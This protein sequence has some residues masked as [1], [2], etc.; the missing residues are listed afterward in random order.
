MVVF[1]DIQRGRR[2]REDQKCE[3][4]NNT[5]SDGPARRNQNEGD[6]EMESCSVTSTAGP[7][8]AAHRE[9]RIAQTEEV[10]HYREQLRLQRRRHLQQRRSSDD[11]NLPD[12]GEQRPIRRRGHLPSLCALRRRSGGE[13]PA[14]NIT[15][16]TGKRRI[17]STALQGRRQLH[18]R[19]RSEQVA[20]AFSGY[21]GETEPEPRSIIGDADVAQVKNALA[22]PDSDLFAAVKTAS[23]TTSAGYRATGDR[24]AFGHDGVALLREHV[25]GPSP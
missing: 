23:R 1:R 8:A 18:G 9:Q 4:A 13:V 3:I 24:V 17:R 16:V 20:T 6:L 11:G 22:D 5:G 15:Y 2:V 25:R 12:Y 19:K 7:P 10:F 14:Q 21:S